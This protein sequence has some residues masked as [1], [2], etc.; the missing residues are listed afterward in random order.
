MGLKDIRREKITTHEQLQEAMKELVCAW[1][2]VHPEEELTW[3]VLPKADH[4]ERERLL[5][6]ITEKLLEEKI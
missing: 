3:L 4:R 1:E 5:K 6:L 2:T